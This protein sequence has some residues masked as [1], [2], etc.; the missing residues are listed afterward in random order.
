[1]PLAPG[2]FFYVA[3]YEEN[4]PSDTLGGDYTAETTRQGCE[5]VLGQGVFAART[6]PVAAVAAVATDQG[7]DL[8]A[9]DAPTA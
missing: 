9:Q 5:F 8:H 1:M 2:K 3:T 7:F 6:N 4:A